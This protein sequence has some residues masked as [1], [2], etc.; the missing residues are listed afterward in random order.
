[1]SSSPV[2]GCFC[3]ETVPLSYF[4][5]H[6]VLIFVTLRGGLKKIALVYIIECSAYVFL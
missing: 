5:S 1:M 3:N 2:G 4:V 6:F